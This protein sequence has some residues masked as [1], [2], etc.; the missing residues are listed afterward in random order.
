MK[1]V[2]VIVPVY[3]AESY[4]EIC[5]N[6]VLTQTYKNIELVIVND[7][8]YDNTKEIL[9]KYTDNDN[10]II[11]N[12]DNTGQ[13]DSRYIGLSYSTGDFIFF[14]DSD[15]NIRN[16]AIGKMV[17]AIESSD[18]DICCG[19]Y[20]LVN[21][22]GIV[23]KTQN[24]YNI[25]V[26]EDNTTITMDALFAKNIKASLW[27][28]L[29]SRSLI[30]TCYSENFQSIKF[31]EDYLLSVMTAIESK[32]IVLINDIVYNVVQRRDSMSRS[33][34]PEMITI[35]DRIFKLIRGKLKI[36]ESLIEKYF[37]LGYAKCFLYGMVLCASH[38]N[39]YASFKDIFKLL[40]PSSYYFDS[41]LV[42][43][44]RHEKPLLYTIY[45]LS[46]FKRLFYCLSKL[47]KYT[48]RH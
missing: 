36:E 35:H 29:F 38:S 10:I 24:K 3:N 39:E 40:P 18:A 22:D 19:R 30:E 32:K 17:T 26:L 45:L 25:K 11:I 13:T 4:I 20:C 6:S 46:K 16:D 34:K 5:V 1:K 31:N 23:T 14:A 43:N 33:C 15:D 41:K 8:S 42:Y 27:I 28:K 47:N 12:K 48:F 21:C 7:G 37:Y 44:L 2:S 9:K